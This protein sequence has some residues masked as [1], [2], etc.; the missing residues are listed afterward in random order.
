VT[1]APV[2]A[3]GEPISD[4]VA[5]IEPLITELVRAA[6]ALD[7]A[8]VRALVDALHGVPLPFAQP[9]A[10]SI[11]RVVALVAERQ[12]DAGIALPPLAMACATLLDGVRGALTERE[13][14]AARYEID[15]LLPL[16]GKPPAIVAPDVPVSALR[17]RR[18][19]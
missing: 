6:P 15:T 5:R 8:V 11:A 7:P 14:E 4:G 2:D 10:R 16:P 12:I 19:L 17:P 1:A 13:L 9:L 18:L 3:Q